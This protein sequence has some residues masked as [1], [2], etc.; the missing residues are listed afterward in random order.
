MRRLATP[1]CAGLA[2]TLSILS[3]LSPACAQDHV[4]RSDQPIRD[5]GMVIPP[6]GW[7]RYCDGHAEDV[8]CRAG[9]EGPAYVTLDGAR[10]RQLEAVNA[11]LRRI[12]RVEDRSPAWRDD[13]RVAENSGDCEDIALA[14][15]MRLMAQGWPAAALRLATVWT[16]QRAYHAV[17]TIEALRDGRRGTWVLDSR[18][19]RVLP[20]QRLRS[21]GY[22]FATRQAAQ[23]PGWVAVAS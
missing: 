21:L 10:W 19:G 23:S 4:P 3:S 8:G 18:M 16:E 22:R 6:Y 9:A 15:R 17:L 1:A 12:R 2:L 7:L 11:A 13:W 20:W 5:G 14:G